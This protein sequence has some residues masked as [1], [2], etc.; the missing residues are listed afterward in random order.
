MKKIIA[1]LLFV[2]SILSVLS[3]AGCGESET[4]KFGMGVYAKSTSIKNAENDANGVGQADATV[5]AVLLDKNGKVL[6]CVIDVADNKVN[7]SADGKAETAE[8]F[9]TKYELGDNYGMKAYGGAKKEWYEQSDAFAKLVVGKA[10]DEIKAL[11]AGE[12][13][14]T[15][16]VINAGCTIMIAD[17]VK[18]I[19]KAI[20]NATESNATAEDTLKLGIVS[21]QTDAKDATAEAKGANGFETSIAATVI[22]ADKKVVATKIDCVAFSVDFD[23]KGVTST[24][25]GELKTKFELGESYGMKAYAGAKKEWFEQVAELEKVAAGKTSDEISKLAADDGKGND[26][27]QNA[28]CTIAISDLIK[29]LLKSI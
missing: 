14:G 15:D 29:A 21:T 24:Q 17:F 1:L 4:V 6:K 10:S 27:V 2:L 20:S 8:A 11:V 9:K 22:N 16:E 25:T 12:N 26:E 13:K 5:A 28:G 23:S 3:L 7:F 18:A 19:D